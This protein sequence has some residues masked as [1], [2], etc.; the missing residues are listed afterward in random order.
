MPKKLPAAGKQVRGWFLH[1]IVFAVVNAC[2]MVY[3]LRRCYRMGLPLAKLD[4]S[5]MG[6]DRY[7]SCL[8]GLG[9]L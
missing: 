9:Q 4:Y 8:P 2:L 1:L 5:C 6:I 7:W 3:M